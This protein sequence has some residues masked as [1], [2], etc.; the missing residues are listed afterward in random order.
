[1]YGNSI[2]VFLYILY[3]TIKMENRRYN[4]FR[5]KKYN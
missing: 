4:G 5:V 1:M 2:C 3:F